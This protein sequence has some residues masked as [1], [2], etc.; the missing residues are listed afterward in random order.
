METYSTTTLNT[1]SA[2]SLT[3]TVRVGYTAPAPTGLTVGADANKTDYTLNWTA[4]SSPSDPI[5]DYSIQYSTDRS[6]WTA[7]SHNASTA[8]TATVTGLTAGA[9]Y[10]F[11]VAAVTGVTGT[12][13]NPQGSFYAT[14]GTTYVLTGYSVPTNMTGTIRVVVASSNANGRLSITGTT[15]ITGVRG[16]WNYPTETTAYVP[17][18]GYQLQTLT[19]SGRMIGLVAANPTDMNN[20]LATLRY[21]SPGG[22]NDT[23]KMYVSNGTEYVAIYNETSSQVEFHYYGYTGTSTTW[24]TAANSSNAGAARTIDGVSL[25]AGTPFLATARYRAEDIYIKSLIGSNSTWMN[26]KDD[27]TDGVWKWLGPDASGVQFWSGGT[28]GSAVGGEYQSWALHTGG[29]VWE[30]N[31]G[32]GE[33]CLNYGGNYSTSTGP[34]NGVGWNDNSCT[35]STTGYAWEA[36]QSGSPYGSNTTV[37]NSA[38]YSWVSEAQT[39]S[40]PTPLA[41]PTGVTVASSATGTVNL[42]WVAPAGVTGITSYAVQYSSDGS[43]W[44][45]TRNTASTT[46]SATI[47]GLT[48][49]TYYQFRIAVKAGTT[50][51]LFASAYFTPLGTG[52]AT[53]YNSYES[54]LTALSLPA[55]LN[56]YYVRVLLRASNATTTFKAGTYANLTGIRG[57]ANYSGTPG[58]AALGTS[59]QMLGFVGTGTNVNAALASLKYT[60][61]TNGANTVSMWV[62]VGTTASAPQAY[63]PVISANGEVE[64]HYFGFNSTADTWINSL[65]NAANDATAINGKTVSGKF[66]AT[67]DSLTQHG[68][69]YDSVLASGNAISFWLNGGDNLTVNQSNAEGSWYWMG[70][71]TGYSKFYSGLNTAGTSGIVNSSFIAW[72][73]SVS[74]QGEPN[75]SSNIENCLQ[76]TLNTV[77]YSQQPTGITADAYAWNDNS[78]STSLGSLWEYISNAPVGNSTVGNNYAYQTAVSVNTIDNAAAPTVVTAGAGTTSIAVDWNTPTVNNG[79][80]ITGYT[81][82]YSTSST[83]A[84]TT[85]TFTTG[86]Q[87]S[88]VVTGLAAGTTY[89]FRVRAIGSNWT[90]V[91]SAIVSGTVAAAATTINIVASGGG[92]AGTDYVNADGVIYA[93]SSASVSVSA[94]DIQ[95]SLLTQGTTIA[96]DTVNVN[97]AINWT[98]S[99]L[100]TLGS[101]SASTVAINQAISTSGT[102]AGVKIVPATYTLSVKNGASIALTGG[103]PSLN[104]GGNNYTLIKSTSDLASVTATGYFAL[105]KPIAYANNATALTAS[106]INLI[107]TGTFDGLGNTVDRMNI[108]LTVSA[109][110]GFFSRVGAASAVRNLGVTNA[111]IKLGSLPSGG[112]SIGLIAGGSEGASAT[113]DQVWSSGFITSL[114]TTNYIGAGGIL[115][116]AYSG[117]I[118]ISKSW[119]SA[120]I[121]TGLSG[122]GT[123]LGQGGIIGTDVYTYGQAP[124]NP[125]GV[126]TLNQVYATGTLKWVSNAWRGTGGLFGIHYNNSGG[127]TITDSFSWV[128]FAA[129]SNTGNVAGIIP[130]SEGSNSTLTRVYQTTH[131]SCYGG[132]AYASTPACSTQS[133]AGTA[134]S[135]MTGS[136]WTSSGASTLVNLPAPARPI[137]VQVIAPS[138]GTYGSMVY[139]LVDA[140]GA[141]VSTSSLGIT[142]SGTPTYTINASTANGTYTVDYTGGLTFGGTNGA[143]YVAQPWSTPTSV[144]ISAAT[145]T[146]AAAPTNLTAVKSG[147]GSISLAWTASVSTATPALS[148][149]QIR[150]ST[151]EYMTSPTVVTLGNVTSAGLAALAS[152]TTY[153]IQVRAVSGSSWS[154][155]YSPV[156]SATPDANSTTI[157]VVAS[158][159]VAS[160]GYTVRGGTIT[161]S[162]TVNINGSDIVALLGT[163]GA[164]N[165]IADNVNVNSALSWSSNSVLKLGI[166]SASTVAV[167]ANIAA[168]G[169]TA[170]LI[171]APANYSL[172]VKSGTSI[173]LTGATPSLTIGGNAYTLLKSQADLA[174]VTAS[175]YYALAK[176]ITM[177]TALTASA[178]PVT[179]F[180]GTLDGL[181]NTASGMTMGVTS[182]GGKG[183]ILSTASGAVVKNIGITNIA[184]TIGSYSGTGFGLGGLIGNVSGNT[185]IDQV[186]TTGSIKTTAGS[187]VGDLGVGGIVGNAMA[188]TTSITK[189]WSSVNIDTSTAA[190]GNLMQGGIIGGAV[191]TYGQ[192]IGTA[193]GNISLNQVYSTGSMKWTTANGWHGV[194]GIM[195]L[196]Y[197]T[198]TISMT[199]VFAWTNMSHVV[200][201]TN[202]NWGGIIGVSQQNSGTSTYTRV[203]TTNGICTDSNQ[204][205][206]AK[207]CT[208]SGLK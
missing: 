198:G 16:T 32:T 67:D 48:Q 9:Q 26:A 102:A 25:A 21:I 7:W 50:T 2:G 28:S 172:D 105:A 164:V 202:Y 92:A 118:T 20:A 86:T 43:T 100:L 193:G 23:I 186:W 174:S 31:G 204:N 89:Y 137:Y 176:P 160:S 62:S 189:S 98:T 1:G 181:G 196:V 55:S 57:T 153:Y 140:Q 158:G 22:T 24:A 134:V 80:T 29:A 114:G 10:Y 115:G 182:V 54:S 13:S 184:I 72:N 143:L 161:V 53:A 169:D 85:G 163:E 87:S 199:D 84:T 88:Y 135:G 191:T 166:S 195:G 27:V 17:N 94:A 38:N 59:G 192:V 125:G 68:T 157:N 175:G 179:G 74:A 58:A 126:V 188:G 150:Y 206:P 148:G 146:L 60:S 154:T 56:T 36:Y 65:S 73:S 82:D 190:Y 121:D 201:A 132:A 64:F 155:T 95:G 207:T 99:Q 101:S 144:T 177:G 116:Q 142:V 111:N 149:Y 162:G 106:P 76:G 37:A 109:W 30:P 113:M 187:T 61:A 66:L 205:A 131:S 75:N 208:T 6:T 104:I 93:K 159:G 194:G 178:I 40:I 129:G 171:I 168:S 108:S 18:N 51:G 52:Q 197:S 127:A 19:S 45:E 136:A 78:C 139:Q 70:K 107:F 15:G 124:A 203:Y 63:A 130:V 46:T 117:S 11:R 77:T 200:D 44:T 185:T 128:T 122:T 110:S 123:I 71:D 151:S 83:F 96:A 35:A 42:T 8:T 120:S 133:T 3:Q 12:Y 5:V 147:S 81:L 4:P 112:Y 90:G 167:N 152:G 138:D 97:A 183:F 14:T 165:L 47:T 145:T 34:T 173:A 119:S 103:T 170:G 69:I 79:G 41:A 180:A 156:V 39:I 141:V 49:G 91:Y 33:N